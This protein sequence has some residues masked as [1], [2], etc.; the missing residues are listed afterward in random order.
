MKIRLTRIE[1][2]RSISSVIA[3]TWKVAYRGIV[4][5]AYLDSLII[6]KYEEMLGKNI[7]NKTE[8]IFVL[9]NQ[10]QQIVGMASGGKDRLGMYECELIAIY[11]LPA[12]QKMGYGKL[13]FNK[14]I[15]KHKKN[16]YKSMIIWTFRDNRDRKFY[17]VM[18]GV[19]GEE[20]K[21]SYDGVKI[22]T[23]G[24]AWQDINDM[25]W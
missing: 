23:V 25:N 14:I 2:A 20:K 10:E 4:P 11:I 5:D 24:Y 6:G 17:E 18:G 22:A 12:Y 16:Q 7:A 1:D 21:R 15:E 8:T 3:N 9:E 19:T 13:M